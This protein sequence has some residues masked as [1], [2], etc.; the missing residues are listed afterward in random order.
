MTT[1]EL[2]RTQFERSPRNPYSVHP[3]SDEI[4]Q[5]T[6]QLVLANYPAFMDASQ[7]PDMNDGEREFA[8][9]AL[10]GDDGAADIA[11]A[12]EGH[13]MHKEWQKP[14]EEIH[15]ESSQIENNSLFLLVLDVTD[16]ANPIPAASLSIADCNF[17]PSET[18]Q[19][20]TDLYGNEV[21]PSELNMSKSDIDNGLWDVMAVMA[22]HEYRGTNASI[23]AYSALYKASIQA[24]IKRWT[25]SMTDEEFQMIQGFMGIPF[26]VIPGTPQ[27][28]I[29]REGKR[30]KYFGFH[31]IDVGEIRPSVSAKIDEY[32]SLSDPA[33][34][35]LANVA[36]LALNGTLSR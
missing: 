3:F 5:S 24:G 15:T 6:R 26:E 27:Y 14:F 21:V 10:E 28:S 13:V 22:P 32:E 17:G 34:Q 31:T 35:Q 4:L 23:W 11:R 18:R 16:R 20:Y 8:V 2:E 36:R 19:I 30:D 1:L 7:Y 12:I 33:F 9:Y 25:A 29:P